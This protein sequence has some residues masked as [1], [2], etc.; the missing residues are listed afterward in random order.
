MGIP[1]WCAHVS[2]K[3]CFINPMNGKSSSPAK[4]PQPSSLT[5]NSLCFCCPDRG[6]KGV[7]LS[8]RGDGTPCGAPGQCRRR[9]R[10]RCRR[11]R[12]RGVARC[13][14]VGQCRQQQ[15]C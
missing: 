11:G 1:T 4:P 12:M 8:E 5:L 15:E 13:R 9:R 7:G 10:R 14:D 2:E 6:G 3:L